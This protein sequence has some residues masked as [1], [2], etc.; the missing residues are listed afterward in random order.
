MRRNRTIRL[1]CSLAALVLASTPARAQLPHTRLDRTF[2]LGGEAGA[3]VLVEIVGKDLDDVQ[4][5]HFDHPGLKAKLVKQNQFR[6]RVARGTP[7][8]TYEVRAVGK[9]GISGSRLFAVSRGL[10]EVLETEPN[11]T[12]AQAQAV[13]MNAAVNGS[14]DGNGDDYFR[15]PVRKGQRV[16][17]DCQAFRLDSTLRATLVLST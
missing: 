6:V 3:D 13:P 8:G 12:P 1:V 14:S 2:P 9:H 5:L 17:V 16:T 10:T 11:D 15:F 4:A 7:P